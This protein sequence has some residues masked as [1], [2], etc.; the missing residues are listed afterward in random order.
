MVMGMN[1][2]KLRFEFLISNWGG[3]LVVGNFFKILILE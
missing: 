2:I 1:K 3:S